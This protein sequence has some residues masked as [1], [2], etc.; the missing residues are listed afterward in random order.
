MIYDLKIIPIDTSEKVETENKTVDQ[1][2]LENVFYDV[3][4]GSHL[5]YSVN[6]NIEGLNVSIIDTVLMLS[7]VEGV[8]GSGTVE[9]AASDNIS[10]ATASTSFNV[11]IIPVN[12]PPSVNPISPMPVNSASPSYDVIQYA[13]PTP[14][15]T[16]NLFPYI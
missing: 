4:N 5:A 14:A 1:I 7:F 12:D 11:E 2:D 8:S 13:I 3:E 16:F 9:I 10:R 6:E 15:S